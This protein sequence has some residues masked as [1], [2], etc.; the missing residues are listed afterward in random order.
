[1]NKFSLAGRIAL[2][3]R[4]PILRSLRLVERP[5]CDASRAANV[6][7][8]T[9]AA[10]GCSSAQ[11]Q[12]ASESSDLLIRMTMAGYHA[13]KPPTARAFPLLCFPS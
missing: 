11:R 7:D 8:L 4:A 6:L 12:S 9:L 2:D 10:N 13:D 3:W 1:M 5:P